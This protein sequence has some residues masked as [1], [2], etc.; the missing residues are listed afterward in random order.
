MTRL[1]VLFVFVLAVPVCTGQEPDVAALRAAHLERMREVAGS[2][3]VLADPQ[4]AESA[5]KLRAEPV[6]RYADDTRRTIESALWIWLGGGRPTALL[7]L[8]YFPTGPQGPRWLYEVA[9]LST[10]RIAAE[11][12]GS[13][14]WTAAEPGLQLKPLP[15]APPPADKEIRRLTQMKELR[16]RFAAFESARIEG[17]IELRPLATPLVRYADVQQSLVDGAIFSLASGTNPEVLLVLEAHAAGDKAEWQYALVQLTGEAVTASSTARKSGS[18]RLLPC[19]SC[20]PATSTAGSMRSRNSLAAAPTRRT[21]CR[22]L[23]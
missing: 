14:R 12:E 20:A 11:C 6:L 2:I 17:R 16:D 4:R 21:G 1:P 8:E 10:E 7:A 15:K 13:F 19:P 18:S 23:S 5:V 3:R 9:S 22:W